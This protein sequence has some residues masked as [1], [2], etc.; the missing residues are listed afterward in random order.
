MTKLLKQVSDGRETAHK[1][2]PIYF[3]LFEN[4]FLLNQMKELKVAVILSRTFY[5]HC[6]SFNNEEMLF[7]KMSYISLLC[8]RVITLRASAC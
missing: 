2:A 7:D 6:F 5:F 4:I 8:L 3:L 1:I